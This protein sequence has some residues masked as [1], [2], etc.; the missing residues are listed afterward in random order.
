MCVQ[1]P[2]VNQPEVLVSHKIQLVFV[3]SDCAVKEAAPEGRDDEVAR[4]LWDESARLVGLK[5]TC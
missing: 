5:D 2:H 1:G 4:K 3:F